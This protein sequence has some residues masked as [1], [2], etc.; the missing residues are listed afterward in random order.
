[1]TGDDQGSVEIVTLASSQMERCCRRRHILL[2][3]LPQGVGAGSGCCGVTS[4]SDAV[5]VRD[6]AG[7]T[8]NAPT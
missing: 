1:V 6:V 7:L 3:S 5:V 8:T 4:W 2:R